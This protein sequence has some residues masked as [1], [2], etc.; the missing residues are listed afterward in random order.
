VAYYFPLENFYTT[1]ERKHVAKCYFVY[2]HSL[3]CFS[4][5]DNAMRTNKT[6]GQKYKI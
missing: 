5:N 3:L 2:N 1:E 6:E 4:T